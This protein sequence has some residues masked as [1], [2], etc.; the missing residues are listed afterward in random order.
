MAYVYDSD[1]GIDYVNNLAKNGTFGDH[2][3]LVATT[4][5]FNVDIIVI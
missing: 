2:Q 4:N 3:T 5:L 1:L